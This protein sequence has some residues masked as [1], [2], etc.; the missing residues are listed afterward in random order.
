ME[1]SSRLK[2][3][4]GG[5]RER[6]ISIRTW[7]NLSASLCPR[8]PLGGGQ[9]HP[10][11]SSARLRLSTVGNGLLGVHTAHS[12]LPSDPCSHSE[13][14]L[15]AGQSSLTSSSKDPC[16]RFLTFLC[17]VSSQVLVNPTPPSRCPRWSVFL[18]SRTRPLRRTPL[19][20]GLTP[21]AWNR[22]RYLHASQCPGA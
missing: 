3:R 18:P 16:L 4:L 8:V 7:E 13:S 11:R 12:A 20:F 15:S 22:L 17:F 14:L 2:A 10:L 6:A 21:A 9:Q 1:G 5:E 19:I